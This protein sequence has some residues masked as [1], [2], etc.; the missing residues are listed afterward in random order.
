LESPAGPQSRAAGDGVREAAEAG[1]NPLANRAP[2]APEADGAWVLRG[3]LT[4]GPGSSQDQGIVAWE[5][6]AVELRRVEGEWNGAAKAAR[7]TILT[8]GADGRFSWALDAPAGACSVEARVLG[9]DGR[10]RGRL[11]V[12]VPSQSPAPFLSIPVGSE[13]TLVWGHVRGPDGL[14]IAAAQVHCAEN[15]ATSSAQGYYELLLPTADVQSKM[16]VCDA[17]GYASSEVNL[18]VE[19]T[20]QSSQVDFDLHAGFSI[21][22][23]VR[24]E[25]GQAIPGAQVSTFFNRRRATTTAADGSYR[26]SGLDPARPVHW[27]CAQH[28]EYVLAAVD[29]ACN[30]PGEV[31]VDLELVRGVEVRGQVLNAQRQPVVGAELYIGFS[32]FAY[33]KVEATSGADGR[34]VFPTVKR[35]PNTLVTQA[36]D[37]ASDTRAIEIPAEG[38]T[39]HGLEI[40]LTVGLSLSGSVVSEE[41]KPIAGAQIHARIDEEYIELRSQSS[42]NGAFTL[43]H[44]P[45]GNLDLELQ[46]AGYVRTNYPVDQAVQQDLRIVM[47][48]SGGLAGRVV[49]GTTGE[50]LRSFRIRFADPKLA[51]GE[52]ALDGYSVTWVREGVLFQNDRG[53][54]S[55]DE[56]LLPGSVT[57]IEASAPGYAARVVEHVPVQRDP[58]PGDCVIELYPATTLSG[59]VTSAASGLPMPGIQ[60]KRFTKKDPLRPDDPDDL[61]GRLVGQTDAAGRY[62][63]A[64]VPAGEMYLAFESAE[65]GRLVE[66]P[67]LIPEG[68][69]IVVHDVVVHSEGRIFGVVVD[70]KGLPVPGAMVRLEQL[71]VPIQGG[72]GAFLETTDEQGRFAFERVFP[73]KYSAAHLIKRPKG[74]GLPYFA[75]QVTLTAGV[76]VELR[77][78]PPGTATLAG[79]LEAGRPL[80]TVILIIQRTHAEDGTP[81]SGIEEGFFSIANDG[82]FE[83]P[84]LLGGRY[85]V[86]GNCTDTRTGEWLNLNAEVAVGATGTTDVELIGSF[87]KLGGGS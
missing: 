62:T 34:F 24:D 85:Q 65:I 25:I 36:K 41:G 75:K 55:T 59:V 22:G 80:P 18:E 52:R 6:F 84:G 82:R 61:H 2:A 60:V 10:L 66:G 12:A 20:T 5:G 54:W 21:F 11:L 69:R 29:V 27:L 13:S 40:V 76:P 50:P 19:A 35:G 37:L 81:V 72:S 70:A 68:A 67:L 44:V 49:D 4:P 63:I 30:G 71:G 42:G 46:A 16:L 8:C 48:A 74:P 26:V 64:D 31:Q 51:P 15:K 78:A 57:G 3:E 45:A 7:E 56:A 79:K 28:D 17:E 43:E 39:L 87:A 73:G 32:P 9:S 38:Q 77:L 86:T 14:P 33:D 1:G 53:E 58:Q 83:L 23:V 47:R